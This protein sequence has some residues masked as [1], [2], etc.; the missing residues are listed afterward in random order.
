[1]YTT[2]ARA[3]LPAYKSNPD[4]LGEQKAAQNFYTYMQKYMVSS[5]YQK[6]VNHQLLIIGSNCI[7][8]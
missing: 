3:E 7:V 1:M 2:M 6:P 4:F 5:E 8:V